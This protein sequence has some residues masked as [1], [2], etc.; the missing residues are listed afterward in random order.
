MPS[1]LNAVEWER[2]VYGRG[3]QMNRYPFDAVVSFVFEHAPGKPRADTRILEVGCGAANNLWFAAREGFSVAGIDGSAAAI[4]YA[5]HRFQSDGLEGE[6]HV[7]PLC[8]LP[9][10]DGTFDLAIDRAA[11]TYVTRAEAART[12]REIRRVLAPGGRFF[13]NPYSS[14]HTSA[15]S[16]VARPDGL[17]DG[18][19]G[20]ALAGGAAVCFYDRAQIADA[21]PAAAW[22]LRSVRHVEDTRGDADVHADWR[23]VAARRG[24]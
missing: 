3:R 22:D 20:G 9:F 11:I 13:F 14:R 17:V 15:R 19:S 2:D 21:F 24:D 6:F 23:V 8:P 7:G 16:G 10:S 12:V 5:R 1:D 4:A 18:I